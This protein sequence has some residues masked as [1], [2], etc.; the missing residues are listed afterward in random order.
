M[1]ITSTAFASDGKAEQAGILPIGLIEESVASKLTLRSVPSCVAF[2]YLRPRTQTDRRKVE[3]GSVRSN[4]YGIFAQLFDPI[5]AVFKPK[6]ADI[7]VG[8][9]D[10]KQVRRILRF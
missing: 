4:H 10:G 7:A 5:D 6:L 9:V 3:V 8:P 2:L 1:T